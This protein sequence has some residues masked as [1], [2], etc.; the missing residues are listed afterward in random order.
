[1]SC[2]IN[3]TK[4]LP[5]RARRAYQVC[6]KDNIR[7]RNAFREPLHL[8]LSTLADTP[9]KLMP[10]LLRG[11]D[12]PDNEIRASVIDTLLAAAA[13]S[14]GATVAS[15]HAASLV[16]TMLKNALAAHMPS[17]VRLPLPPPSP[18]TPISPQAN[19]FRVLMRG[20]AEGARRGTA[21]PC[22]AS[23]RRAIRRAAPA[24]SDRRPRARK[25]PGRPEAGGEGGGGRSKVR[26][27]RRRYVS[28][29]HFCAVGQT[30]EILLNAVR[31]V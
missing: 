23:G 31:W 27:R 16:A 13:T 5:R 3:T 1:M 30:G 10:L 12:L 25:G 21:V 11:L 20:G 8:I 19:T 24:E 26:P 9:V 28:L 15:E 22:D 18:S 4:R 6:T 17:A 2:R 14:D 7:A 29:S